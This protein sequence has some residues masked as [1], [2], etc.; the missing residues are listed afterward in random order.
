VKKRGKFIDECSPT[1]SSVCA[2]VS[3]EV[4][5]A[6]RGIKEKNS[7]LILKRFYP[8]VDDMFRSVSGRVLIAFSLNE[9]LKYLRFIGKLFRNLLNLF[10]IDRPLILLERVSSFNC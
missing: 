9:A 7:P 3:S 2:L 6:I 10:G 5:S 8:F 1:Q 4:D